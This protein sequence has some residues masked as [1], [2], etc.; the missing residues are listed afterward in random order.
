MLCGDAQVPAMMRAAAL[1]LLTL[2]ASQLSAGN[3]QD[4]VTVTDGSWAS[5]IESEATEWMVEFY[6]PWVRGCIPQKSD[7]CKRVCGSA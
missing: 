5:T 1:P 4:V 7:A 2:L 6:A 3:A